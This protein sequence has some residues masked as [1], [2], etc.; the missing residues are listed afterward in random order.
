MGGYP[1]C[2]T[3]QG[4]DAVKGAGASLKSV[5]VPGTIRQNPSVPDTGAAG[6]WTVL[7]N[8]CFAGDDLGNGRCRRCESGSPSRT[9]PST[10]DAS[11]IDPSATASTLT[12]I[13][14][15]TVLG[16]RRQGRYKERIRAG[17]ADFI[18]YG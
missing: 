11:P 12:D 1:E 10:T 18:F 5:V 8:K 7:Q 14:L 15:Q 16:L 13:P 2:E 17:A 4:D 6:Q 3:D 9:Y